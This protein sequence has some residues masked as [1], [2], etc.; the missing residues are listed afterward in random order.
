MTPCSIYLLQFISENPDIFTTGEEEDIPVDEIDY[1]IFDIPWVSE[2]W[3][4]FK[5]MFVPVLD[6]ISW[7][8]HKLSSFYHEHFALLINEL[9]FVA[10]GIL[11]AREL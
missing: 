9:I 1:S 3:C 8:L 4:R 11:D 10:G 5:F 2:K 6:I 7:L